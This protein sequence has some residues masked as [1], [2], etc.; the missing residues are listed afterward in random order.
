MRVTSGVMWGRHFM[1][2]YDISFIFSILRHEKIR[3]AT[4]KT[5]FIIKFWYIFDFPCIVVNYVWI[6]C[7]WSYCVVLLTFLHFTFSDVF[8]SVLRCVQICWHWVV[9]WSNS[10]P[11]GLTLWKTALK[12]KMVSAC[13]KPKR[14]HSTNGT[15]P[16][17]IIDINSIKIM[18]QQLLPP[19]TRLCICMYILSKDWA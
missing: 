9:N 8:S 4:P 14:N 7:C 1:T 6:W 12:K 10:Q 15:F 5:I 19:S 13:M 18:F 11:I 3:K 16:N 2:F 17:Y